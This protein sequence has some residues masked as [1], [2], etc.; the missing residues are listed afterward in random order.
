MPVPSCARLRRLQ[1]QVKPRY[2]RKTITGSPSPA[3]PLASVATPH[4]VAAMLRYNG[5]LYFSRAVS[6]KKAMNPTMYGI[7]TSTPGRS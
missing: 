6:G 3:I 2:A 7:M 5:A 4:S 1:F